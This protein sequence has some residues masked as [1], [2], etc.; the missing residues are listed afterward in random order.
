MASSGD[1][2]KV[3][4]WFLTILAIHGQFVSI[5]VKSKRRSEGEETQRINFGPVQVLGKD[6]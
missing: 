2:S 6:N 1:K 4:P 5:S 3:R